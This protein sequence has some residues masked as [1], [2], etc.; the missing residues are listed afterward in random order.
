MLQ[1]TNVKSSHPLP[2][3]SQ[4]STAELP[5]KSGAAAPVQKIVQEKQK[6]QNTYKARSP[7]TARP[8][9]QQKSDK[10]KYGDFVSSSTDENEPDNKKS[11]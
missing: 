9:R 11:K 10:D 2:T 4:K 7:R 6:S 5:E 1:T 3:V 8:R